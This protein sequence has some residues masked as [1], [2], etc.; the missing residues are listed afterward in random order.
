MSFSLQNIIPCLGTKR[1]IRDIASCMLMITHWRIIIVILI[2]YL[3]PSCR[4]GGRYLSPGAMAVDNEHG[5]I[6]TALN[7]DK[8]ISIADISTNQ[9]I[10]KIKL[11]QNPNSVL[12]SSDGSRLFASSG[13]DKGTVEIIDLKEK[14]STASVC[15]GHSPQDM[16]LSKNGQ[17]LYVANKFTNDISV[18]DLAQNSVIT[19][20]PVKREPRAICMTPDGKT[21]AVA[22]FLPIQSSDAP[23]VAA[24]ITLIDVISNTVRSNVTLTNGAQSVSGLTCS[25]DGKYLY[26]IHLISQFSMPI[27]QL[28]RGWVNTNALSIIDLEADSVYAAVLLDDVD[29]GAANPRSVCIGENRKMYIALSGTHEIMVLELDLIHNKLKDL[30]AGEIK[31]PYI[32]SA[33]DLSSSLNF[34]SPFKK[35]IK[36]QGRFPQDVISVKNTILASC[37]FSTFLECVSTTDDELS[38]SILLGKEPPPDATRRGELAFNDASIC[39][40]GWQSCASCH[41]DGRADGL[42]WDQQN[43]GLGNP[44]NTK[45]LLFSHVTPPSMITG[46]RE[47]AELAVRNGIL[48]TL[49]TFQPEEVAQ[50][51]DS[52]LKFLSPEESPYL[53]EY[54]EKDPQQK[55]KNIFDKAG[56]SY[57][58]NGKYLTDQKKY[59]VGTGNGSDKDTMFDT[60]T[61]RE[62]WRTAPYLYDGRATSI[63]EVL[64]D[65]N[66]EDKHGMT[67]NLTNE[68]LELLILYVN[69][70]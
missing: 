54:R 11:N 48:H 25:P 43:D 22:N 27:T 30:F 3:L 66:K 44:K 28:D 61:L 45:S 40:Q 34:I 32:N 33:K 55:G 9:A 50:D 49:G 20:I 39:F 60:P 56:C 51:M 31:D 24:E 36:L 37:R 63:K 67:Q 7:T 46:I 15:V 62:I 8:S 12:L 58:H 70:L 13:K 65:Y 5:I 19:S 53:K 42:N 29:Y 10:E 21:L 59:N 6:Y 1:T 35:R 47:T 4:N 57:C 64:T 52:Y 23:I 69:T 68:E 2:F 17:Y 18:I 41:P 26:A 38:S 16:A 14:K